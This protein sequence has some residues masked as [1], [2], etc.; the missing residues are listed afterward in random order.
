VNRSPVAWTDP[1]GASLTWIA[2]ELKGPADAE[3]LR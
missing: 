1:H 2:D 3:H